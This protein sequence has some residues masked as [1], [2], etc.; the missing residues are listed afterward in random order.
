MDFSALY[1]ITSLYN[2]NSQQIKLTEESN[3]I[4][5]LAAAS[6]NTGVDTGN[7]FSYILDSAIDNINLTNSYLSDME[8]E[9]LGKSNELLTT[10]QVG[11]LITKVGLKETAKKLNKAITES[12]KEDH[13]K[14]M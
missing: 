13:P 3:R 10:K 12:V 11:R 8:N 6:A 7:S 9:E 1:D 4:N 2:V 14:N 5:S